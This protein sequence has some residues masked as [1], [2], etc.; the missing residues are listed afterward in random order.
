MRVSFNVSY[1]PFL[2]M[3]LG[4][5]LQ[6]LFLFIMPSSGSTYSMVMSSFSLLDLD[7]VFI[8]DRVSVMFL[9]MVLVV[10]A[11]VMVFGSFYMTSSLHGVAFTFS[12]LIFI[13]S[14]V[15]LSVTGSLFWLFLGW[16]GLGLS[17]F[18]LII[19]NKNWSSSKSGLITFLMNRLGDV[20]MIVASSWLLIQG[21]F[22]S[23]LSALGSVVFTIGCLSKS[24]QF[25]LL[26]WL[27]EAMA[28]PTPVSSLVHSSTLVTAGIYT[29]VRFGSEVSNWGSIVAFS[30]FSLVVSGLSALVSTDLKKVVAYSTLSHI[31]LMI[32]YLSEGCIDACMLHMVMHAIF[33]SLLF[34]S[35]G[36]VI[37]MNSGSQDTRCLSAYGASTGLTTFALLVS[38]ISMAGLPYLS[39]G[40][41]KEVVLMH[42][43]KFG[44]FSASFFLVSVFLTSSYSVRI[45]WILFSPSNF[46]L[47]L[48]LNTALF[49]F[50]LSLGVYLNMMVVFW[51]VWTP[52]WMGFMA[53]ESSVSVLS[54][55]LM[56]SVA[57]LGGCLGAW[58]PSFSNLLLLSLPLSSMTLPFMS[59][60]SKMT[61]KA[62]EAVTKVGFEGVVGGVLSSLS[63]AC[64]TLSVKLDRMSELFLLTIPSL[65]MF[66]SL[67]WLVCWF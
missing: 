11:V 56:I 6:F 28:A 42:S 33:K 23:G 7:M 12:M 1:T 20:L 39:G 52:F 26:S 5:C 63:Q 54:K 53:H 14:M 24:A 36:S 41:S 46:G 13:A 48:G 8:F 17:S 2:L 40:F 47:K 4:L 15:I 10:S 43:L 27:P 57:S 67:N 38:L 49:S 60:V 58:G 61:M 51:A 55:T 37:F 44:L 31:S 16:D 65:T 30:F 34:M 59:V 29:L 64:S 45:M 18:I 66:L 9:M 25:P 3:L 19:F 21:S 62:S 22:G 35:V 50:S 32:H